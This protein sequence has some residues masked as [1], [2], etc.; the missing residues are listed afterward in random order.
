MEANTTSLLIS[1]AMPVFGIIVVIFSWVTFTWIE[2]PFIKLGKKIS[3][4]LSN[5]I[6]S[7]RS[8]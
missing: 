3:G 1:I 8:D 6:K 7:G 5:K 2:K 4:W